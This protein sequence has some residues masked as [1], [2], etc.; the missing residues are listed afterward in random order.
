MTALLHPRPTMLR[1]FVLVSAC[2]C[3]SPA[4]AQELVRVV[5]A[6]SDATILGEVSDVDLDSSGRILALDT[7]ADVVYV[8]DPTGALAHALGREGRGPG[9]IMLSVDLEVGPNDE[10][11]VADA[12]N[13]RLTVWDASGELH[14]SRRFE[15]L[16][17]PGSSWPG[18][19]VWSPSGLFLKVSEFV[20]DRPLQVF[21]IP[22]DFEGQATRAVQVPAGEDAATCTFCSYTV[23][24]AG[25]VLAVA[26]DTLYSIRALDGG[27]AITH[28]WT[29]TDLPAVRRSAAELERLDAASRRV[30]GLEGGG[31]GAGGFSVFKTRFGPHA[32]SVDDEGRLWTAPR[33]AEGEPGR[34]DVF[35]PSGAHRTTI[36]VDVPVGAFRIRGDRVVIASETSIGEPVVHLF[37]IDG[38]AAR[39]SPH[40]RGR[41]EITA[42]QRLRPRPPSAPNEAEAPRWRLFRQQL[43]LFSAARLSERRWRQAQSEDV[44]IAPVLAQLPMCGRGT[45]RNRAVGFGRDLPGRTRGRIE[46]AVK[47]PSPEDAERGDD[48]LV[49]Q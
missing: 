31:P 20:P 45:R 34:F 2:L 36:Q 49:G 6:P 29:R 15:D 8:F 47:R 39:A 21:R 22:V 30:A 1:T 44:A 40:D 18:E 16:L 32:L 28:E 35:D 24:S 9:E 27:G 41:R 37:R 26:P 5:T 7:Q 33:V 3:A 23:D 17:G 38:K 42:R 48:Q 25:R 10:V 4:A 46:R 11:V 13:R 43:Q 19:L 12:Q 14:V